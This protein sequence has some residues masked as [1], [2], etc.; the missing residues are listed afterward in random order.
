ME[1]GAETVELLTSREAAAK[2]GVSYHL[3][4]SYVKRQEGFPKPYRP[5]RQKLLWRAHE[6]DEWMEKR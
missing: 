2:I 1:T 4:M 6:I 3:F 5:A